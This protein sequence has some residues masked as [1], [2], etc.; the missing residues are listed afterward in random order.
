MTDRDTAVPTDWEILAYSD[1]RLDDQ[2][3]AKA[4]FESRLALHPEVLARALAYRAQTEAL[5]SA[6]S[7]HMNELPPDRLLSVVR[8]P[9]T[10]RTRLPRSYG[11]A[12]SVLA[13]IAATALGWFAGQDPEWDEA[14]VQAF[15]AESRSSFLAGQDAG[16]LPAN[17]VPQPASL[18][19]LA[20][21]V[22]TSVSIPNLTDLGYRIAERTMAGSEGSRMLQVTYVG[23][24]GER[25]SLFLKPRWPREETTLRVARHGDLSI[26]MWR[27]GPLVSAVVSSSQ[28]GEA[29]RLAEVVGERMYGQHG[30]PAE[31]LPS[32]PAAML[33]RGEKLI[34]Q[35]PDST[36]STG[37]TGFRAMP[38]VRE[39]MSGTAPSRMKP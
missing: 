23:T 6:Y 2:P 33:P 18:D 8:R 3:A 38:V 14:R 12:A 35:A 22:S 19:W 15:L 31:A 10:A 39:G 20:R 36:G 16:S 21:E 7:G 30:L 4:A 28:P 25:F 27:A 24:D 11:I 26:A 5:R 37:K 32:G 17:T 9:A 34:G 13:V 1:G 29:R